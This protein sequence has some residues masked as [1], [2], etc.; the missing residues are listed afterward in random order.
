LMKGLKLPYRVVMLC[1]G[2]TGYPSAK[3]Y[4]IETWIPSQK[5]YR[6]THS[7]SNC[8][9]YQ[10]RHLNIRYRNKK[11][12]V[13]LLHTLNGTAIAIGRILIAIM[14]NGQQKDGSIKIPAVLQKY[15][16]VKKIG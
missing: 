9:D 13:E 16:G 12:K 7:T 11:G 8:T 1:T 2:D 10:A 5:K 4:D 15:C 6:E 14:E 3:T